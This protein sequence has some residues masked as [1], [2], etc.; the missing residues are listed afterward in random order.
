MVKKILL[1]MI[2]SLLLCVAT[3]L[4]AQN[5]LS[6]STDFQSRY[7]WRGQALGKNAPSIQPG[8]KYNWKGLSVGAWGAFS[9]SELNSQELDLY[10]SYTFLKD[11]FTVIVTDYAFP[12]DNAPFKYFDYDKN[13]TSHVFEGGLVFNGLK[14]MPLSAAVY[15]NFY[16]AD[17]KNID[18]DNVFSTYGEVSYNPICEK[19]NTSFNFF[20]GFAFNGGYRIENVSPLNV[21]ETTIVNGFYGNEGFAFVNLGMGATKTLKITDSFSLPINTKL[22]FNPDSNKAYLT[23]STGISL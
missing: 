15:M 19:L 17:A 7:I 6:I 4:K 14:N 22:I 18:G 3:N 23:V 8:V 2:A 10:V 20:A 5:N 21:V 12:Q 9:T 13:T 11:M 16:G 1:F